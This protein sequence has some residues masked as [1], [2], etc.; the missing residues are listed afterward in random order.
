MPTYRALAATPTSDDEAAV[1]LERLEELD[2]RAPLRV[3]C[4]VQA[5]LQQPGG[6]LRSTIGMDLLY[7]GSGRMRSEAEVDLEAAGLGSVEL[8]ALVV[9][10]GR[11][12]WVETE[13][14][15]SR[16]QVAKTTADRLDEISLAGGLP[17][18][19]AGLGGLD[20]FRQV[21]ELASLMQLEVE[22]R[23]AGGG[24][25]LAGVPSVEFEDRLGATAALFAGG[26]RLELRRDG[27]P[28]RMR[29]GDPER[30][31]LDVRFEDYELLDDGA[32]P[33][34]AFA[35]S[36]PAGVTVQQR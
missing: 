6:E 24:V 20:P 2:R 4:L 17:G 35:Y 22:Q 11:V 32:L 5:R 36:P 9:S 29:L 12:V 3:R 1:W 31:A 14:A 33:G 7:G 13:N 18:M 23:A 28:L 27:L 8:R 34:D 25:V 30:P 26:M 16:P 19:G 15:E 21:F 10:D